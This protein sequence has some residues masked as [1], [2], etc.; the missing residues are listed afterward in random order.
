MVGVCAASGWSGPVHDCT[1]GI[2]SATFPVA[3]GAV[4]AAF[5]ACQC[6]S[7][8]SSTST[9]RRSPAIHTSA[10]MTPTGTASSTSTTNPISVSNALPLKPASGRLSAPYSLSLSPG[11]VGL[12]AKGV[13]ASWMALRYRNRRHAASIPPPLASVRFVH[14]PMSTL[15]R[16]A[17]RQI[18]DLPNPAPEC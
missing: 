12:E 18:A 10:M 13:S 9:R 15:I 11:Q 6:A 2:G 3:V 16:L 17:G 14:P 8:C 4:T 5:S 1:E 7:L